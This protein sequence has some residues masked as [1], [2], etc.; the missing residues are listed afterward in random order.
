MRWTVVYLPDAE[1]QLA[2]V[3]NRASDRQ[4]VADASDRLD[5]LLRDDPTRGAKPLGPFYVLV[6]DP[7]AVLLHISPDDRMVRVLQ[8]RRSEERDTRDNG[9]A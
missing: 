7:L 2:D 1:A 8:V 6:D 9:N 5:R 4:A 3:W